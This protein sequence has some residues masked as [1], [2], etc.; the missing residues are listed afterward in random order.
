MKSFYRNKVVMITGAAGFKGSWLILFLKFFEA[1]II[2]IRHTKETILFKIL[3]KNLKFHKIYKADVTNY[4]QLKKIITK[5]K[6]SV[7]FH[8]AAQPLV[9]KSYEKPLETFRVNTN[10]TLNIID[11]SF[12]TASVKSIVCV[13]TDK[14]YENNDKINNFTESDKLGGD[15]PYSGSKACAELIAKSYY[16][17]FGCNKHMGIATARAGNVIGGGDLSKNRLIP[18]IVRAL[19]KK[20]KLFIR[21]L[22]SK[23]P[24][25]HVIEPLY[26]YLLLAKKIYL[27]PKKYSGAYN[28]GPTYKNKYT[29]KN[30]FNKF[31]S[32]NKN[33]VIKFI[34]HKSL[35]KEKKN[36]SLNSKKSNRFLGWKS[37]ISF[38]ETMH[39][40]A[41]WFYYYYY[42][43]S[44]ILEISNKHIVFF[45]N[46][47][48]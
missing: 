37:F 20:K 4:N 39:L 23:R 5:E 9:I 30:V 10:G 31:K 12:K 46:K 32:F 2:A 13:T 19:Y 22:Y 24:W 7:I 33:K 16:N 1:K 15:D 14:V 34:L 25:Q 38:S 47:A 29:V 21:N 26:G 8:L 6:P 35:L 41:E 40:T 45:L 18:D 27:Q 36:L 11:I 43:R 44:K 3:K 48:K 42:Y 28:F 17:S